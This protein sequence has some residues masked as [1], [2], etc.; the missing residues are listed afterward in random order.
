MEALTASRFDRREFLIRSSAGLIHCATA[1]LAWAHDAIPQFRTPLPTPPVLQPVLRDSTADY[2]EITQTEA[3][4]EI[5]P[6]L[7]TRVWGYNGIFPGPTIEARRGRTAVVTHANRL[8]VP[9]LSS[10]HEGTRSSGLRATERLDF[11]ETVGNARQEGG[12]KDTVA[13]DDGEE[14]EVIIR[15]SGYQ[16]RYLLHCHNL[17]H[18]DHSMMA[19]VDVV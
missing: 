8:R 7:R 18:E 10:K 15:W 16:G 11:A 6:G 12:W 9:G 2:Y 4:V 3:S 1:G 19:R 13:I 17:E 5:I 14:V